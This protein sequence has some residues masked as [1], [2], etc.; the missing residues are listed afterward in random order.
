ML[1]AFHFLQN[2]K[3]CVIDPVFMGALKRFKFGVGERC[4]GGAGFIVCPPVLVST[5]REPPLN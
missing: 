2:C 3:R 1:E 5:A 4:E